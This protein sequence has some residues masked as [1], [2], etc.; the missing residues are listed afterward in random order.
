MNKRIW[1]ILFVGML[2]TTLLGIASF[3]PRAK[4]PTYAYIWTGAASTAAIDESSLD[5]YA[6][7]GGILS[8]KWP[9]N[10]TIQARINVL[11]GDWTYFA[12][13][14]DLQVTFWDPDGPGTRS[15][16]DVELYRC[17]MTTGVSY[18][19]MGIYSNSYSK[20]SD[21]RTEDVWTEGSFDFANNAY[22]IT[23]TMYRYNQSY[24]PMATRIAL[25]GVLL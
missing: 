23:I 19:V 12:E 11:E 9:K 6:T 21:F 18:R 13:A 20:A 4:A 14:V 17:L 8:F 7:T 15:R 3:V 1:A 10:G 2:S 25:W 5:K 22:F 24:N 16:V